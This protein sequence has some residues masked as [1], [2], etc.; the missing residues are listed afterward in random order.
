MVKNYNNKNQNSKCLK[1]VD[2]A[3]RWTSFSETCM[4]GQMVN[5]IERAKGENMTKATKPWPPTYTT[6]VPPV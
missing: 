5:S 6:T 1:S 2:S 3:T 4:R